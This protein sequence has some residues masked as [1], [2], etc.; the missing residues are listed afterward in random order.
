VNATASTHGTVVL[1]AGQVTY[2]PEP[3]FNGPASFTYT[4][5]DNGITAG[6]SDPKCSTATVN[7]TVNPVPAIPAFSLLGLLALCLAT[8]A[9]G[10]TRLR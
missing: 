5:C 10:I 7:V 8:M 4:V 3:N 1:G 6:L 2:T 9:V